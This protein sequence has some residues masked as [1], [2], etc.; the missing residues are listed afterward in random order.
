[1]VNCAYRLGTRTTSLCTAR[2]GADRNAG[3]SGEACKHVIHSRF[4]IGDA[5]PASNVETH[6]T[7]HTRHNAAEHY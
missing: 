6:V 4:L 1:M 5:A 2:L 3:R 7:H